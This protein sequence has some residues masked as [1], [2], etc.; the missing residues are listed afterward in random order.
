MGFANVSN[1]GYGNAD[2]YLGSSKGA[3]ISVAKYKALVNA[4]DNK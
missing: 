3:G 4:W 1:T 2:S